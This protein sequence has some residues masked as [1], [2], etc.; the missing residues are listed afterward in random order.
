MD[1]I[2][3][4]RALCQSGPAQTGASMHFNE[5]TNALGWR[6]VNVT[7]HQ[8]TEIVLTLYVGISPEGDDRPASI[9]T[10]ATTLGDA[11]ETLTDWVASN[12]RA[13]A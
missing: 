11:L 1:K 2:E 8:Q 10:Y 7:V 9:D 4:L 5:A 12:R 6:H 3:S 13:A